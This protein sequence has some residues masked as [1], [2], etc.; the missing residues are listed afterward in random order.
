LKFEKLAARRDA[1]LKS[2]D[3]MPGGLSRLILCRRL[4]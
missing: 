1:F 3:T 4:P 2:E